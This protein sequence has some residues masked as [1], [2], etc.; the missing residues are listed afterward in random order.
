MQLQI[1]RFT[2]TGHT[3]K[4]STLAN[5][6]QIA[7]S[8][9]RTQSQYFHDDTIRFYLLYRDLPNKLR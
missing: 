8:K 5:L 1:F 7:L 6:G 3:K 9:R 4:Q 2:R